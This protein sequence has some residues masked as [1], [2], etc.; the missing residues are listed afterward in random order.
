MGQFDNSKTLC[1]I[2]QN[3]MPMCDPHNLHTEKLTSK[4][5]KRSL[6]ASKRWLWP[7]DVEGRT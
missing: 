6:W 4:F 5:S 7:N 3:K 1:A 2:L